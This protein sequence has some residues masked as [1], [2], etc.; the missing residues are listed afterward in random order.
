MMML[1]RLSLLV[2]EVLR[3]YVLQALVGLEVVVCY[4]QDSF[5]NLEHR[6]LDLRLRVCVLAV[7]VFLFGIQQL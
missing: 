7:G 5:E 3:I 4:L 6:H 2:M 1:H